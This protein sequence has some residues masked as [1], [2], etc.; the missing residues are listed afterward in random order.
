MFQFCHFWQLGFAVWEPPHG[1]YKMFNY[2]WNAY[3]KVS[4]SLRHCAFMIMA[5][6]GC[7]LSEIQVTIIFLMKPLLFKFFLLLIGFFFFFFVYFS[8]LAMSCTLK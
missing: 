3:V 1:R 5:M 7:M 2:P 4:G 6:H 8:V